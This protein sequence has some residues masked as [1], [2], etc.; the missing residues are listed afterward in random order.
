MNFLI[1]DRFV[2]YTKGNINHLLW[3]NIDHEKTYDYHKETI[4]RQRKIIVRQIG[5]RSLKQLMQ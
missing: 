3:D 1:Y 2:F 4:V 5:N